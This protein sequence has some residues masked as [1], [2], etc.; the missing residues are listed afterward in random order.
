MTDHP[1]ALRLLAE[2]LA[3]LIRPREPVKLSRWLE[4]NLVLVDGPAAGDYWQASGAP[5]LAEIADCLGDDDPCNEVIVR[6]SQQTGASILALGWMLYIAECEPA[7]VLYAVP[8]IDALR[9]MNSQKLQPLIDAWE[10]KTKKRIIVPQTSR[11]GA[12]STTYEKRF[13][14]GFLFLANSNSV[15]DLS[16]KTIKKGVMDELSKWE[17]IP[18]AETRKTSI[19]GDLQR[20]VA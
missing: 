19:S 1:S 2:R 10:K 13:P 9:E 18:V 4:T 6:K 17:D 14:G 20:S 8:G 11:S 15:M 5:Y 7:N 3:G 12:G 16:G